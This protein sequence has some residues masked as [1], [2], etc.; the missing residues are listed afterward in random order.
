MY[1]V[2]KF[3]SARLR[4]RMTLRLRVWRLRLRR[5]RLLRR[6]PGLERDVGKA[7]AELRRQI[8]VAIG[9]ARLPSSN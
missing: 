5:R 7:E 8:N 1:G 2:Y 6:L 3:V 9:R 4:G